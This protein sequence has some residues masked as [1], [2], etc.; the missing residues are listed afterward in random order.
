VEDLPVKRLGKSALGRWAAL[1]ALSCGDP[2]AP[3]ARLEG[4]LTTVMDLGY[5]EVVLAFGGTD[6]TTNFRRKKGMGFDTVLSIT[7]RLEQTP[8]PDGGMDALR[9]GTTYSLPQVLTSGLP[10]GEVSRNVLDDPRTMFP[11]ITIGELYYQNI[12]QQGQNLTA[13]G[14]FHIT[15]ETG[16]EFASGKTVFSNGFQASFP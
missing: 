11:P 14:N 10:R 5:D 16:V 1:L 12:P 3:K 7:T 4:S 8:L 6:F 2:N 15:F 13:A 9:G